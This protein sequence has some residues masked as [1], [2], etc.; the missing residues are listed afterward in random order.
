MIKLF[1]KRAPLFLLSAMLTAATLGVFDS[2]ATLAQGGGGEFE[3]EGGGYTCL[4][5]DHCGD[6]GCHAN[7]QGVQTCSLYNI[8]PR[9]DCPSSLTCSK[10]P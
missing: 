1:C 6:W 7:N 8:P 4:S 2:P 5:P 10:N 9:T 3:I